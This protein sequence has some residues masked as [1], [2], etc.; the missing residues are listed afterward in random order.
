MLCHLFGN[1]K[2]IFPNFTTEKWEFVL[3]MSNIYVFVTQA[4]YRQR[5]RRR[6]LS[7]Q[8]LEK[9]FTTWK[10]SQVHLLAIEIVQSTL[11]PNKQ[12]C[13]NLKFPKCTAQ[14]CSKEKVPITS[15]TKMNKIKLHC[16]S[17]LPAPNVHPFCN[18][19]TKQW[20]QKSIMGDLWG[21]LGRV[22]CQKT[23]TGG[24]Y[25]NRPLWR[26]KKKERER[27]NWLS[28]IKPKGTIW[29]VRLEVI[30]NWNLG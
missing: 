14:G 28:G 17:W 23:I 22:I 18:S 1:I 20:H 9:L 3:I 26:S 16:Q 30:V 15:Q 25:G 8:I 12:I 4:I 2:Q 29:Q 10:W 7:C 19:T 6:T 11:K 24:N 27:S 5:H 13:I 21:G